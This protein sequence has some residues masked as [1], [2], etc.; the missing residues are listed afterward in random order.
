M[1]EGSITYV[2]VILWGIWV[3]GT[4]RIKSDSPGKVLLSLV[5]AFYLAR[6][7]AA[8]FFPFPT[9]A[10]VISQMQMR[11]DAGFGPGNNFTL[12]ATVS[13]AARSEAT[14]VNQIVGNFILLFPLGLLAPLL[15]A[16]FRSAMSSIALVV[17]TTL[18]IEFSQWGISGLLGFTYRSFDVD[19]LWLNAAGGIVG[20][21]VATTLLKATVP[22]DAASDAAQEPSE[23][24][25]TPARPGQ[26]PRSI[27]N[28]RSTSSRETVP[29]RSELE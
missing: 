12:F 27:R 10:S 8:T 14:F 24:A 28:P 16:R 26:G 17:A 22:A 21:I 19:D 1:L 13:D 25:G 9:E 2:I 18:A 20:V 6:L 4:D 7:L 3:L 11:S 15:F 5:F 29:C 23:L